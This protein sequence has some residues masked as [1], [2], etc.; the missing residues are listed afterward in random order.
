MSFLKK[1]FGGG[2]GAAPAPPAEV[3]YEGFLIT[4]DPQKD[5]GQYRLSGTIAKEIDGER[6]EH[7]LIR[8]DLF[9][10]ADEAAEAT[11]HK[12]KQVIDEQGER[13]FG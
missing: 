12:A 3:E 13:L 4:A 5:N 8:A 2:N 9:Q 11:L 1:I 10:S 7:R 6:K